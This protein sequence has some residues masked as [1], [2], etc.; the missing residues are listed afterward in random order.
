[1]VYEITYQTT[2]DATDATCHVRHVEF[3][4]SAAPP[5]LKAIAERLRSMGKDFAE[6]TIRISNRI[7]D[8]STLR[9]TGFR[10]TEI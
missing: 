10:V 9:Q 3:F 4:E 8:A 5:A 7:M 1:M 2:D 6:D